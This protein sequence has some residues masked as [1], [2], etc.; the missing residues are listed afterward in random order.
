MFSK[1]L[2]W[3]VIDKM[4]CSKVVAPFAYRYS[5]HD[6]HRYPV[7]FIFKVMALISLHS[8]LH[9]KYK[10]FDKQTNHPKQQSSFAT[11][12]SQGVIEA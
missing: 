1:V 8:F 3:F 5:L 6:C 12:Q 11:C 4:L 7:F 9:L 2:T 10:C